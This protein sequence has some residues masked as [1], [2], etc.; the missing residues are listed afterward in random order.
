MT[1][2]VSRRYWRCCGT[3]D[4]AQAYDK[5]VHTAQHQ[6]LAVPTMTLDVSRRYWRCC[7]TSDSAQAYD[8]RVHTA[9]HQ[10]LAVPTMT[11][12]VSRRYWRCCG[13][14]DSAQA[15]DKRVHTA[16]HQLLAVPTMTLDVSRR[17]WRCCGT[18]DS[19]QAY[20]KRVHTA[21]HQL[22]AVPTM[23]LDDIKKLL[24][25]DTPASSP[26][27][28][29]A[30]AVSELRARVAE[31][32]RALAL[33]RLAADAALYLLWAHLRVFLRLA[34]PS[35]DHSLTLGSAWRG[36]GGDELVELRKGLVGVFSDRFTDDLLD[37]A[38]NQ[39][40]AQRSFLEVLLKDIKS[41]IQF[42]PL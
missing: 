21:Q 34:A 6:L 30:C 23:T 12:D 13:T 28:A 39:P 11:L 40:A 24:P 15:Y 36:A 2:D 41:M 4:S 35:D 19:A 29:R 32:R 9:Q 18:S 1:L 26:A 10:L 7:G 17:Y 16:Q 42:S 14:S 3:S 8:K 25:E 33:A 38:K 5:R 20:D 27:E 31:R 37:N 22:L